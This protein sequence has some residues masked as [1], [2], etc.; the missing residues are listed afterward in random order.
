MNQVILVGKVARLDKQA[1]IILLQVNKNN[2]DGVDLIPLKVNEDLL[3]SVISYIK[4]G[5]TVGIKGYINTSENKLLIVVEK[6]TFISNK[7]NQ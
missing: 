3:N 2:N 6:L 7:K 1:G 5:M 4:D